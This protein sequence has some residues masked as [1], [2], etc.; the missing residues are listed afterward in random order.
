[1]WNKRAQFDFITDNLGELNP[2]SIGAGLLG[3]CL[4]FGMMG[5]T[6]QVQVGIV[7]RILGFVVTSIVCY[8]VF[9]KIMS[10]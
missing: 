4:A 5:N 3:G 6:G 1:M 2:I 8:V 7:W 9:E 10:R